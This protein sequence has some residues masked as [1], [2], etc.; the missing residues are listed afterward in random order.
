MQPDIEPAEISGPDDDGIAPDKPVSAAVVTAAASSDTTTTQLDQQYGQTRRGLTS[1]HAQLMA[2]G[3]S[4]GTALF[5]GVA[6]ALSRTGALSLLL[7]YLLW[8]RSSCGP[9][10]PVRRRDARAAARPRL[11]LRARRALRR[12]RARLRHGLDVLLRR[13]HARVPRVQ[14]RRGRRAVL[15]DGRQAGRLDRGDPGHVRVRQRRRRAV[16]R[17]GGV[18]HGL[19]EGAIAGGAAPADTRQHARRQPGRR[20]VRLPLL[21]ERRRDAL[22]PRGG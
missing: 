22:I 15:D 3:R 21:D 6:G 13:R 11:H 14:R 18:R 20:R 1:R 16:V 10:T 8:A 12:P 7:G 17:R 19:P 5:V 2:I 9:S 4:I